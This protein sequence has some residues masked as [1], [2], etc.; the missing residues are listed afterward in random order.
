MAI[1]NPMIL[2][3]KSATLNI[4]PVR[5][6]VGN[7]ER[8]YFNEALDFIMESNRSYTDAS[9]LLYRS[10][11]ESDGNPD[12]VHES[13]G[14]FFAKIKEIIDRFLE[15][16]KSLVARFI[17]MLSKLISSDK[18]LIKHK[19]KLTKFSTEHEFDFMGFVYSF[20]SNVPLIEPQDEFD[21]AH[22]ITFAADTDA[23]LTAT[24]AG[25]GVSNDNINKKLA[26][27]YTKF[28][29]Y[30]ESYY[31]EFRARVIG[32]SGSIS[33]TDFD[34]E[35]FSVYRSG[36]SS[37][38]TITADHGYV[39]EAFSR[40]ETYDK[41]KG[42]VEKAKRHI[43]KEY[44]KVKNSIDKMVKSNKSGGNYTVNMNIDLQD[45][46]ITTIGRY[47]SLT[48]V[49]VNSA[50]IDRINEYVRA[51]VG[52]VQKMSDI[53]AMAFAA[54]LDALKD[55]YKQDKAVCYKALD[56]VQKVKLINKD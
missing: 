20:S 55:C 33:A 21:D 42:E 49:E 8:S 6:H 53:H 5:S 15:F 35:L 46:E 34:K 30:L 12:V 9:I 54:K 56:K 23:K 1:F 22:D 14:D 29:D 41:V 40:F 17:T 18:H 32:V 11:C 2:E 37:K 45:T 44:G 38:E 52:Q 13:F 28:K 47:G 3:Q 10:L 24:I 39:M 43:E 4:S 25:K 26:T 48:D 50:T 7:I 36:E 16:I 27:A 51:K 19:D 31:D